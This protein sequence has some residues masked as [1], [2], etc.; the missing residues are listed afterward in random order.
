[1]RTVRDR[2]GS[3][4]EG[5]YVPGATGESGISLHQ[6]RCLGVGAAGCESGYSVEASSVGAFDCPQRRRSAPARARPPLPTRT[7]EPMT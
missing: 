7:S 4:G 1:M 5:A 2:H 6:P 3:R